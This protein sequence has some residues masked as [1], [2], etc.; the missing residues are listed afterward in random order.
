MTGPED[1]VAGTAED[2]VADARSLGVP[3]STRMVKDWVENG[4][5]ARPQFRKST[6]RGS[7]PGLFAPEQRV[8][9]GKLIEAKLRS[10]LPR[11]PHHT[12]VPVI[13]SMWLSDDRVITEDQARRALRTYARSAGRRSLASRTATAR[14][15]IEQFAHPEATRQARRDVELLLLDGEKSR[16][17]R[18]DTLV[19]AMK[20]LAAP[21][22][23]DADGL[24]RLDART[25]GLPEMPVT[26]DYA[27]GLW[28][29][30]GEVTQQLE[31]ESIQPHALLLAREEFRC[32]WAAYQNDRAALAARGGADAA[33]FAEPTGSEA[34]IRE[35]VDSFTSTL[36]RVAGLADPVFDAVRAGLRR[37]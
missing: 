37:R 27:I 5:L 34:R 16:C 18:W 30:K 13:I 23:H 15:V 21:W 8:L 29:V 35:H 17:P 24:S 25:I 3:A 7:D 33:L 14:A 20:D 36:G 10:P 6:Q 11:V 28:M 12:V 22:R 4:L 32:G 1:A 2:L 9:F 19:P 31:M 26:F